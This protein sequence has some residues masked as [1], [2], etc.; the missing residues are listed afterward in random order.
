MFNKLHYM[1]MYNSQCALTIVHIIY[2]TCIVHTHIVCTNIVYTTCHRCLWDFPS[3][4]TVV[5][6]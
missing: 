4:V 5:L 6:A 3:L 2:S 1:L